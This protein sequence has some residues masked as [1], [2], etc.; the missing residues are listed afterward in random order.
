MKKPLM[1]AGLLILL[2]AIGGA[3]TFDF[4]HNKP[5]PVI[6]ATPPAARYEKASDRRPPK[7]Q[8][9][10]PSVTIDYDTYGFTPNIVSVAPGTRIIVTN[11]SNGTMVFQGLP[12]QPNNL[13]QLNLGPIAKGQ[14][15][16][17]VISTAGTWQFMNANEQSDRGSITVK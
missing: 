10:P 16:S 9:A 7:P 1:F 17:F 13:P 8:P 11:T 2:L 6:R 4:L 5:F 14:Q 12:G 15:K 3:V